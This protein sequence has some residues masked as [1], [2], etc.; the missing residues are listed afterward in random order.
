MPNWCYN[1]V[2]I[3]IEDPEELERWKETVESKESKFD[4]NKITPM[5]E[6]LNTNLQDLTDAKSK[7]L[8]EKYGADGWYRW[9]LNNW[10]CKWSVDGNEV[11]VN[12]DKDIDDVDDHYI[13]YTFDTAWGPPH[14]IY[15]TLREKFPDVS[16]SWFYDEPGMQFAGY[17]NNE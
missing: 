8:I 7:E 13:E 3:Y 2:E 17:L 16:I 6:E 4:F 10:G 9:R 14:E 5:P 15:L 11:V 1:R 12:D